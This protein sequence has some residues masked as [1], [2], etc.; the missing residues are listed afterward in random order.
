MNP[1][2]AR[3][4]IDQWMARAAADVSAADGADLVVCLVPASTSTAWWHDSAMQGEVRFIRGRLTFGGAKN[5][6]MFASA[7]VIFRRVPAEVTR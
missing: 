7:L 6:A 1:P 2:Y 3:G 5:S 4:V